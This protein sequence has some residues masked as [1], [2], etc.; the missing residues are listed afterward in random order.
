MTSSFKIKTHTF[1]KALVC[2]ADP[3]FVYIGFQWNF[4]VQTKK[5]KAFLRDSVLFSDPGMTWK[6][7]SKS[8]AGFENFSNYI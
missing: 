3:L 5:R 4:T 7:G 8:G 1:I 2:T 6:I